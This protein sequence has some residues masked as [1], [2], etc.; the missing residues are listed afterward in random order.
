M[1]II[2][3]ELT[4]YFLTCKN[5]VRT[6]H[7]TNE[8]KDF[9]LVE[10]N[11][12]M[13]LHKHQSGPTGF[14]RIL[15]LAC[16]HQ[17]RR[18]PFQPFV[19]FEDDVKKKRDFP[20]DIDIPDDTDILYLGLTSCGQTGNGWTH[21]VYL[22]HIDENII[23][24]SNMLSFHGVMICSM[25][26]LLSIQKCMMEGYFKDI[27]WDVFTAQIQP[28]L[29]VYAFKDPLVYQYEKIGG[30]EKGTKIN[31]LN[32]SNIDLPDNWKNKEN[33]SIIT[34]KLD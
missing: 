29:N 7:I 33:V 32:K 5:K 30:M 6:E 12:I 4:Y 19:I 9:N 16:I 3:K 14:S 27:I 26:G 22:K 15:D 34:M 28:H 2:L 8:F 10:V 17:D 25:R 24:I 31:F 21:D 13:N 1:K 11:P 23:K 20:I 18:K